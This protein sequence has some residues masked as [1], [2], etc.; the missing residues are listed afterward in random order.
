M[1]TKKIRKVGKLRDG[2]S[3]HVEV[4]QTFTKIN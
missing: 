1:D 2:K 4:C 3:F